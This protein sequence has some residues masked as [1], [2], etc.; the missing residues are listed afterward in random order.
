M[1][2]VSAILSVVFWLL[3]TFFGMICIALALADLSKKLQDSKGSTLEK[4]KN[5]LADK[6]EVVKVEAEDV[7]ITDT[8][9][10][11]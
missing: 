6:L 1:K 11:D 8:E 5:Y 10:H 2:K 7:K 9:T 4:V 3:S